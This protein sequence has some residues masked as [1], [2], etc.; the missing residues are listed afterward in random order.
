MIPA[1]PPFL[2]TWFN[3]DLSGERVGAGAGAG[4]PKKTHPAPGSSAGR[5]GELGQGPMFSGPG[6]L[7]NEPYVELDNLGQLI[8]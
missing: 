5:G 3:G 1:Q 4:N 7:L 6:R 8:Y 2:P